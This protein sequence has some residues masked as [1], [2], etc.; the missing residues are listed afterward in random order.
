MHAIGKWKTFLSIFAGIIF[1]AFILNFTKGKPFSWHFVVFVTVFMAI[2]M[3]LAFFLDYLFGKR[4]R[5]DPWILMIVLAVFWSLLLISATGSLI[6]NYTAGK[7]IDWLS[8][9]AGTA[10]LIAGIGWLRHVRLQ[11]KR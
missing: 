4:I 2:I 3:S 8:V 10:A 9:F 5:R 7:G 1:G 6:T 11:K